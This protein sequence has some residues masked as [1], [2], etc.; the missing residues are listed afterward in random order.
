MTRNNTNCRGGA[1]LRPCPGCIR[2]FRFSPFQVR[3]PIWVFLAM[4]IALAGSLSAQ[5]W[6]PPIGIPHPGFGIEDMRPARPADWSAPVP[7][8]YYVNNETGRDSANPYGTPAN[9]RQ[10]IPRPIP[11]GAYVEVHGIYR[12]ASGGTTF[13]EGQGNSDDPVW[14]V[15]LDDDRPV[16][17]RHTLIYGQYIYVDSIDWRSEGAS[18]GCLQIGSDGSPRPGDHIVVRYC[19]LQGNGV[20]G[21]TGFNVV[22]L[23]GAVVSHV[24]SYRNVI[25]HYGDMNNTT[26]QDAAPAIV[27]NHCSNIWFLKNTMHTCT[28]GVRAGGADANDA[29]QIETSHHHY[30]GRNEIY[31]TFQNGLSVKY[32]SDIVFSENSIHDIINTSWSPAKGIGFQ[33]GPRRLWVLYNRIYRCRYGVRGASDSGISGETPV[34]IIGNVITDASEAGVSINNGNSPRYIVGNTIASVERGIMNDYY[35]S[36]LVISNN[37]IAGVNQAHIH[38]TSGYGTG[39]VST[40]NNTLFDVPAKIVWGDDIVRDLTDFQAAFGKGQGCLEADPLFTGAAAGDFTLQAGSPARD[41]GSAETVYQTFQNLYGLDIRVDPAGTPR[42]QGS[43]W[44]M[45]AYEYVPS[46]GVNQ[47]INLVAGWNWISFNVLPSDRSLNTI[48]GNILGQVEQ[49]R[50]QT[51][52]ALRLN[53][54]WVGDLANMDGIQTGKMYKVRVNAACTLTVSGTRI[55]ATIPIS[56]VTGWNWVAFFP[57][58]PLPVGSALQ[59][60]SGQVQQVRSQT[61]SA[62]YQNGQWIGDLTQMEPGKGYTILMSGTGALAYPEG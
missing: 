10:T 20:S 50:T 15:G 29:S 6:Q 62:I 26:D 49:V 23:A 38:F 17:V 55:A 16:F 8:Y 5:A 14:V 52:S 18:V 58:N 12:S 44:D 28:S 19:D 36:S 30:F 33:Y 60:I 34:Y 48:F 47:T 1:C 35:R 46:G 37:I 24:V 43:A 53:G 40:I 7:G 56:L 57:V 54:Q 61:Q 11:A 32:G 31:G 4:S 41:A 59:S 51:Q 22:G 27:G 42:P 45:G 21:A 2:M 39:A 25:H 3:Y 13:I 9:P